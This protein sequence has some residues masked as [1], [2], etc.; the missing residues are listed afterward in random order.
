MTTF[1]RKQPDTV[2]EYLATQDPKNWLGI[3]TVV[4]PSKTIIAQAPALH[5]VSWV[6]VL[7]AKSPKK[8]STIKILWDQL[9]GT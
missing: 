8:P 4:D 7:K 9:R 1:M 5:Y 3:V 2:E 6:N